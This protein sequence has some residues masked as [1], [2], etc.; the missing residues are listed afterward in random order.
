M[1]EA[2]KFAD[3]SPFPDLASLYDDV[4]VLRRATCPAGGP[5][6]SAR[7]SRTAASASARPGALPHE[8]A[9]KG[10]AYASVGDA[11]ERRRRSRRPTTARASPR[12]EPEEEGGAD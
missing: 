4:Y 12:G 7:P 8:L 6:T 5:W 1:D 3:D 11:Q 10:A 2:V 9:E